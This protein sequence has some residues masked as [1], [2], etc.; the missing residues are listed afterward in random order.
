MAKKS[1]YPA[2]LDFSPDGELHKK[3]LT[4][5][6]RRVEYSHD[7]FSKRHDK[8]HDLNH[9]LTAYV[10]LTEEE[11]KVR[12]SDRKKPVSLVVP[13]GFAILET[14]L[15]YW[16]AV[17]F[18]DSR[19]FRFEGTGPEDMKNAA[20]MEALVAQQSRYTKA[21]LVLN[22][23]WRDGFVYGYGVVAVS[24]DK[25]EVSKIVSEQVA[26]DVYQERE[27]RELVYEGNVLFNIDPYTY[28]PDPSRQVWEVQKSEFI[29]W[30]DKTSATEEKEQ[31]RYDEDGYRFNTEHIKT[32]V[33]ERSSSRFAVDKRSRT[34]KTEAH[35][36][37]IETA[38][39]NEFHTNL[40]KICIYVNLIPSD[41]DLGDSEYPE[42]WYFEVINDTIITQA[43]PM[44]L[45][46]NM[47][48]VAVCAPDYD[49]HSTAP[50]SRIELL[51]GLQSTI[52][53]MFSSHF[54]N[55]RKAI[56]DMFVV[57]PKVINVNDLRNPVP[58]KIIRVRKAYWG[59]GA[60]DKGIK[61][62][63]TND[64][65]RHNVTDAL[66]LDSLAQSIS[67]ASSGLQG[68]QN[69]SGERVSASEA[70]GTRQ[71]ALSRLERL[72]YITSLQ[73][74][75]D[76]A[77]LMGAQNVQL[78]EGEHYVKILGDKSRYFSEGEIDADGFHGVD[79]SKLSMRYDIEVSDG[80]MPSSDN[81]QT[82]VQLYQTMAQNP[83]VSIGF[84]MMKIF[85]HIAKLLGA[86]NTEAFMRGDYNM[87][88]QVQDLGTI[89]DKV[90]KGQLTAM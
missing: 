31:E 79:L 10:D 33:K 51:E 18:Q 62:L 78:L 21:P 59:L 35:D 74:H 87:Q 42:K 14:L 43:R 11:R 52:D 34:D 90:G 27:V 84:D 68:I 80:S 88:T 82:W 70:Q 37:D 9:M 73:S 85:Q 26:E 15:T 1:R 29:A 46:H 76:I 81:A 30:M 19:L 66:T 23:H 71:S 8:W 63:Q 4:N 58:G 39:N 17:F 67:G 61:Q 5:I 69:R 16:S 64:I 40:D 2:G 75:Q 60:V 7:F 24:W 72:C 83:Q 47:F 50:I 57:D 38:N 25:K 6:L 12:S 45:D 55:V 48:P 53:W 13:T 86:K 77:H 54:I 3:V 41:W 32:A 20:I 89:M 56:N 22:T 65:T 28:F 49:G 44:G 36:D